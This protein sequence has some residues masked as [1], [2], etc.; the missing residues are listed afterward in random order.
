MLPRPCARVHGAR[1]TAPNYETS[2][3]HL[4]IFKSMRTL[5]LRVP[6]ESLSN[7]LSGMQS[8]LCFPNE[9]LLVVAGSLGTRDLN[10]FLKTCRHLTTLLTPELRKLAVQDKDG[11]PALH[12]A[13]AKGHG[14]LV[15]LVLETGKYVAIDGR[16]TTEKTPLQYAVAASHLEI[17]R[18]LL[19]FGS[20]FPVQ[21]RGVKIALHCAAREGNVAHLQE[22]LH[23]KSAE[24]RAR[25]EERG[26]VYFAA[27]SPS[28]QQAAILL[29]NKIPLTVPEGMETVHQAVPHGYKEVV[30]L[31]RNNCGNV[32]NYKKRKGETPLD[33]ALKCKA[34]VNYQSLSELPGNISPASIIWVVTRLFFSATFDGE[35]RQV[36]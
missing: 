19:D 18:L 30:E 1:I 33:R 28:Q 8:L 24:Q 12:W 29:R 17:V 10:S 23:T 3:Q 21:D 27:V 20:E 32:D 13:A 16:D 34:S 26:P 4:P 35:R 5:I 36:K 2:P 9:L 6:S 15:R 25:L 7:T 22:L 11:T 14:P 31:I